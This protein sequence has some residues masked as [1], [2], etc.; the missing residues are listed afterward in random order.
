METVT[1]EQGNCLIAQFMGGFPCSL[2]VKSIG[3]TQGYEFSGYTRAVDELQYH[4][5]WD[6]IMPPIKKFNDL[7]I[8]DEVIRK[9]WLTVSGN[10]GTLV[11]RE[12]VSMCDNIDDA[13]T[14][15]YDIA[16]AYEELVEAIKWYN[17]KDQYL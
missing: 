13:V 4:S 2:T 9:E 6:S 16:D 12:Y 10:E 3:V 8:T 5:S 7:N 14:R 1:T 17:S 11:G 15:K